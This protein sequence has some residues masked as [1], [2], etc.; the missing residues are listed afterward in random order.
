MTVL[1]IR[2]RRI[3]PVAAPV[4]T[5]HHELKNKSIIAKSKIKF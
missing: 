4:L 5:L 3:D 1:K 2:G